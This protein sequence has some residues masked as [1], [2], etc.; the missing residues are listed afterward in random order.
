M[1]KRKSIL[2]KSSSIVGIIC[3]LLS[4]LCAV[5]LYFKIQELGMQHVISASLLASSFFCAFI[6]FVFIVI[7]NADIPSFKVVDTDS[8]A[9]LN[10]ENEDSQ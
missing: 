4:I 1:K 8:P 7:G 6:G 3:F 9:S 10:K 5:A 2:Q